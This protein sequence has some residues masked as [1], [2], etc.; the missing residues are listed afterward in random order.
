MDHPL[1]GKIPLLE[2]E[3]RDSAGR[4][5]VVREYDPGYRPELPM[6]AVRGDVRKQAYCCDVP[7][8]FYVDAERTCVQCGERFVFGAR[9]QKYWYESLGFH[10]DSTAI[11]CVRCRKKKRSQKAFEGRIGAA[12]AATQADERNAAAWL[13]LSEAL[14]QFH[15]FTG[16]GNLEEAVAAARKARRLDKKLVEARLWEAVAQDR[17]GHKEKARQ[18]AAEYLRLATRRTPMVQRWRK[19]AEDLCRD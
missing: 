11:R 7:R 1:F 16:A 4:T 15:E 2:R 12:R 17:A 5:H 18:L 13:E 8:Y 9:E 14:V 3:V 19:M 6:G 10:L